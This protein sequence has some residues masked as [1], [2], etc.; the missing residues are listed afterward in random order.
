MN[1]KI[2]WKEVRDKMKE[3]IKIEKD[4]KKYW[5]KLTMLGEEARKDEMIGKLIENEDQ[6]KQTLD[7]FIGQDV[8]IDCEITFNEDDNYMLIQ[9]EEKKST[10]KVYDFLEDLFFG[11]FLK[12]MFEAMMK[13]FEENFDIDEL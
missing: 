5:V 3:L 2:D 11:D 12:K 9:L 7:Q 4:T 10:N 1:G 8:P 13:A 6:M